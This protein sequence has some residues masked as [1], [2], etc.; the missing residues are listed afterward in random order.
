MVLRWQ[1]NVLSQGRG[2]PGPGHTGLHPAAGIGGRSGTAG[3]GGGI[4]GGYGGLI[5]WWLP[6]SPALVGNNHKLTLPLS[7]PPVAASFYWLTPWPVPDPGRDT[8]KCSDGPGGG[9]LFGLSPWKVGEEPWN[10]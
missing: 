7:F 8:G 3:G 9:T 5:D 10:R 2:G 6:H 4:G 1:V